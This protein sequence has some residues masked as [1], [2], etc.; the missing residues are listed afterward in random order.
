MPYD[1]ALLP[2]LQQQ[3]K[4]ALDGSARFWRRHTKAQAFW[5]SVTLMAIGL[6]KGQPLSMLMA[7]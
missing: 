4:I 3:I 7:P 1:H 2:R 6:S 5:A